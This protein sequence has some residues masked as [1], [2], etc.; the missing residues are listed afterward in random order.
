MTSKTSLLTSLRSYR[1][2]ENFDPL[3]NFVTEAFAW[4][5]VNYPDFG[6]F[7][8][9]KIL[10]KLN[11]N[12]IT[13]AQTVEWKTQVNLRGVYPDLIGFVGQVAYIFEHKTWSNLHFQQLDS[14]R[15]AASKEFENDN[16][17]LILVT[18]GRHQI[19]QNPD[20]ALLWHEVHEWITEWKE[21]RDYT[22]EHLFTDFQHL[23]KAEGMGPP[24]PVSHE[25]IL[26]FKPAKSF[27]PS[28]SALVQR[29]YHH[30]WGETL[31][32]T[33]LK[34][35]IPSH[36]NHY[37]GQDPWGRFGIHLLGDS[38]DWSPGLFAGFL[39]DPTDHGVEWA[40]PDCP[41]FCIIFSVNIQ[42]HPNYDN[43]EEFSRLRKALQVRV[44]DLCPDYQFL[45]HLAQSC[46]PNRWHPFHIRQPMIE[47]LRG[48]RTA[49]EQYDRL[50]SEVSR[51][52]N[53]ICC[54]PE[55]L[56]FQNVLQR[57]RQ[58]REEP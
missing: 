18:G 47:L 29:I 48:T 51:L 8:L 36:R 34:P 37:Y 3:E 54:C 35:H 57:E 17:L 55:F 15:D 46:E 5:L 24:A 20:L 44:E 41:D 28:L 11:M 31:K 1:P 12:A 23:L 19:D 22:P 9:N 27:E 14:Y 13:S 53:V 2:R 33:N 30:N 6:H 56:E 50:I 16:Y 26:A 42:L 58:Q 7:Y 49:E 43:L 10:R 38:Q 52:A 25:S 32:V 21:H 4:L 40:N 39:T 45:D